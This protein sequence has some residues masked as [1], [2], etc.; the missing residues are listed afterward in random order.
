[1]GIGPLRERT[2]NF[3]GFLKKNSIS[4][5][6]CNN[7]RNNNNKRSQPDFVFWL[8]T[9]TF[10]DYDDE[11]WLKGF[12]SRILKSY[13]RLGKLQFTFF[14]YK[15]LNG[16]FYRLLLSLLKEVKPPLD[17]K[18]INLL[19]SY[20]CFY[21]YDFFAKTRSRMTTI[22][23][24]PLGKKLSDL[25]LPV[26]ARK[27]FISFYN[28]PEQGSL[29]QRGFQRLRWWWPRYVVELPRVPSPGPAACG[30]CPK[31]TH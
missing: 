21:Q 10:D 26:W 13:G 12:S 31:L 24:F 29:Y 7:Y 19:T 23:T 18:M 4:L 11:I 28:K 8:E 15:N 3:A 25:S 5:T 9:F 14:H 1:M 20:T 30:T 22:T 27:K 17:R 16:Y 2:S 6:I